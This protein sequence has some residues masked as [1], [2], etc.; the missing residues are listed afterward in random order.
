[1]KFILIGLLLILQAA[2]STSA[3]PLGKFWERVD[4]REGSSATSFV[5]IGSSL[6]AVGDG[7]SIWRTEDRENWVPQLT[8]VPDDLKAITHQGNTLIAV[9]ANGRILRC[10]SGSEWTAEPSGVTTSLNAITYGAGTFVAA[11][12]NG[13][14]IYST[15]GRRWLPWPTGATDDLN[16]ILWDGSRFF[17][18]GK[19]ATLLIAEPG[20][21]WVRKT[22]TTQNSAFH[23]IVHGS[24]GYAIDGRHFSTN[25]NDWESSGSGIQYDLAY[26]AGVFVGVRDLAGM[27]EVSPDGKLWSLNEIQ[28]P[29]NEILVS[30]EWTG[31]EFIAM[32]STLNLH[33]SPDGHRW[34]SHGISG[35]GHRTGCWTGTQYVTAGGN[36]IRTSQDTQWWTTIQLPLQTDLQT[37][38]AGGGNIVIAGTKSALLHSTNGVEWN[39]IVLPGLWNFTDC[40]WSGSEFILI[41]SYCVMFTSPNGVEWTMKNPGRLDA[42][43]WDGERYLAFSAN[44]VLESD[45]GNDWKPISQ[46][47]WSR[48]I[49]TGYSDRI[50]DVIWTGSYYL[51]VGDN[52]WI[53]RSPDGVAW[54]QPELEGASA[55]MP[56][57]SVAWSGNQY[58]IVGSGGGGYSSDG[59]NWTFTGIPAMRDVSWGG[60]KFMGVLG[61]GNGLLSSDDGRIWTEVSLPENL[62]GDS[63]AWTG[64][65]WIIAGWVTGDFGLNVNSKAAVSTS[66]DGINWASQL[67]ADNEF[68]TTLIS[69]NG[70]HVAA[71]TKGNAKQYVAG[72][73]SDQS[74][75]ISGTV[76]GG[77]FGP[78]GALIFCDTGMSAHQSEKGTWLPGDRRVATGR[79]V[80][81]AS[82]NDIIVATVQKDYQ[83]IRTIVTS[84][85]GKNWIETNLANSWGGLAEVVWTGTEFQVIASDQTYTSTTG[86]SWI[87]TPPRWQNQ[88][89]HTAAW[90]YDRLILGGYLSSGTNNPVQVIF[91]QIDGHL[92]PRKT[93]LATVTSFV[94]GPS[95]VLALSGDKIFTSTDGYDWKEPNSRISASNL[96]EVVHTPWGFFAVSGAGVIWQSADGED[97]TKIS[98]PDASLAY[99]LSW[100]NGQLF[101]SGFRSVD[102]THWEKI[103][104]SSSLYPSK[105]IWNGSRYVGISN[106]RAQYSDNGVTWTFGSSS[107]DVLNSIVWTGSDFMAT[108]SDGAVLR[109]ENGSSW[110]YTVIAGRLLSS[111]YGNGVHMVSSS[112]G[113]IYRSTDGETWKLC[114]LPS[115]YKIS[116]FNCWVEF[117][118]GKFFLL[119]SAS[120]FYSTDGVTWS[121][122]NT[123]PRQ[124]LHDI[125][126]TGNTYLGVDYYEGIYKSADGVNWSMAS[127]IPG[128]GKILWNGNEAL[129]TGGQGK[130]FSSPTGDVW[131]A[132]PTGTDYGFI[133]IA[134]TG[135]QYV[136][137]T[138]GGVIALGN[139]IEPLPADLRARQ[140]FM[141]DDKLIVLLDLGGMAILENGAWNVFN[142]GTPNGIN[143]VSTL[144]SGEWIATGDNGTIAR[145][146]PNAPVDQW[147]I[148]HGSDA[149]TVRK[150]LAAQNGVVTAGLNDGL[151][152]TSSDGKSWH[153]HQSQ[154]TLAAWNS[155][156]INSDIIVVGSSGKIGRLRPDQSFI[157]ERSG[158]HLALYSVASSGTRMV[159][160]GEDGVILLSKPSS[161][162]ASYE[163]WI[164]DQGADGN[165]ATANHDPNAD[166][167]ENLVA[168]AF[169]L[170]AT[171]T[172]VGNDR[173]GLPT[174]IS[175]QEDR[176]L[177]FDVVN[178][179]DDVELH[180]QQSFD[181]KT[182]SDVAVKIGK[183]SWGGSLRVIETSIGSGK[184]RATVLDD[185][186]P[187]SGQAFYRMKIKLR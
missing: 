48:K 21:T 178:D 176:R 63:I 13:T 142:I 25:G 16:D 22:V 154:E 166:G 74:I 175:S 164:D 89:M 123:P 174:M 133:D 107:A 73:W 28:L 82:A 85:D 17:A 167:I 172:T 88:S 165:E 138:G 160:V 129:A 183:G 6:V 69:K 46:A 8:S 119:N 148:L 180:V 122:Y 96:T 35:S 92:I 153:H 150:V 51:A 60:S 32:S 151:L 113:K 147:E 24:T 170:P 2:V 50:R 99:N 36:M 57:Q 84:S 95:L 11:G 58:V 179:I 173:L 135:T 104:G 163:Q 56:F 76:V 125:V 27:A 53:L 146:D 93:G 37:S 30:V 94:K 158:T 120:P 137:T 78:E 9:G 171:D 169:G 34:L 5:A 41:G 72:V 112:T 152:A 111:A 108:T 45:N 143:Y 149:S 62:H 1:M 86:Q 4:A 128:L 77:T 103:A 144:P 117:A 106:G 12:A 49:S 23:H 109:S 140:I 98:L 130:T 66:A 132:V 31:S 156:N 68:F 47:P 110:H 118:G 187:E 100:A 181:M 102:G 168:Y 61:E 67:G 131:T 39:N 20:G 83:P 177:T 14:V 26:G 81:I 145:H 185:T 42:V 29:T 55:Y 121:K 182:W 15:D 161:T 64:T 33:T 184:T 155:A 127:R 79:F 141:I 70:T 71:D 44:N 87:N 59:F 139:F 90:V 54:E 65:Q 126:W 75:E 38:A 19:N 80:S 3:A 101:A 157:S 105:I 114:F 43:V 186:N 124:G 162:K 116:G 97:W 10:A 159:A 40:H 91:A 134:W 7:G 52:G 136:A 115:N 18:V